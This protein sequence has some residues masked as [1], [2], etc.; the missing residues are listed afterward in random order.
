MKALKSRFDGV[1][2]PFDIRTEMPS[3]EQYSNTGGFLR[4]RKQSKNSIISASADKT[5]CNFQRRHQ[6]VDAQNHQKITLSELLQKQQEKILREQR[7]ASQDPL[8]QRGNNLSA[9]DL[10][11]NVN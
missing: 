6:I 8:M 10:Y 11:G 4:N 5:D 1:I 7:T 9:A 3:I 2:S